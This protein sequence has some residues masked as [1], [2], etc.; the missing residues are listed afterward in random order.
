[1]ARTAVDRR[2][3]GRYRARYQGPDNRW[4]SR[5]FDRRIDAQRWLRNELAKIDRM[6]WVDPR[7]GRASFGL[8]AERWMAGRASLRE[9]TRIR[10]QFILKSLV[11]PYFGRLPVAAIQPSDLEA[12]VAELVAAGKAPA[13]VRKAWQI[14]SG[15]MRVAVRDRLL[16]VT[17]ARDVRLPKVESEQPRALTVDEVMRLV[18]AIDPRYRV[19]I[20]VG[21]FGGLRIGELA[22]LLVGDFD[23]LRRHI[24]I[25]RTASDISGRVVVGPPKT[26]KS[27]RIV[28]L[29]RFVSDELSAHMREV[30]ASTPSDLIFPAPEGGAIHRTSWTRRFWKPALERAGLDIDLGTHSLRHSQVALLIAQGEHPKVIADRLGHSSVRTV[31]DVYGHLYEGADEAAA[32]RLGEQIASYSRPERVPAAVVRITKAKKAQ[33]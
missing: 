4:R 18:D 20:L 10:D 22:G 1:M 27:R 26:P 16:T 29:P 25:R 9:S 8:L 32:E 19:L 24:H 21:A 17:P 13:T 30:G 14:A 33:S 12:W 31:L 28:V 5:T 15:V 23:P 2:D 11:L 6:E 3:N 7:A